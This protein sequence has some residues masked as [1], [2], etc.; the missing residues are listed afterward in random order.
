MLISKSDLAGL[1][2]RTFG[3]GLR[4]GSLA[5][6]QGRDS[7]AGNSGRNPSSSRNSKE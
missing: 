5:V 3:H 1:D 4:L 6:V 7:Y 2:S